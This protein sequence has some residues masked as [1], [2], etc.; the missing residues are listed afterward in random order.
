MA[1]HI[2]NKYADTKE[3]LAMRNGLTDVVMSLLA[4]SGS[5]LARTNDEKDIVVW[6]ASRDQHSFG[7]GAV[8][9]DL[10]AIPWQA[11]KF[12]T[13]KAFLLNVIRRAQSKQDWHMLGYEPRE[14]WVYDSLET[15]Y[16]MVSHFCKEY[17]NPASAR[18]WQENKPATYVICQKHGVLHHWNGCIV[19]NGG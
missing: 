16:Q 13:E 5:A 12:E 14:D 8:G 11:E 1:N 4:L 18:K 19:C 9:F 3:V 2:T 7:L 10:S 15:L 17:I 6:L